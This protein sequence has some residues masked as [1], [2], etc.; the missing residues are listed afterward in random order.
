MNTGWLHQ[1]GCFE[2]HWTER[3]AAIGVSVQ[4]GGG[5]EVKWECERRISI[6]SYILIQW[7]DSSASIAKILSHKLTF[8]H[9]FSPHCLVARQ[10]THL[11]VWSQQLVEVASVHIEQQCEVV[12]GWVSCQLGRGPW[13]LRDRDERAL[14]ALHLTYQSQ[15][16]RTS[17]EYL[18]DI[19]NINSVCRV[20]LS[21]V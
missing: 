10:Q 13:Y 4:V 8:C 17:V 12:V 6:P 3:A 19:V 2:W 15:I 14:I 20:P 9:C 1:N 5:R 18:P 16:F 7:C 21:E 11:T